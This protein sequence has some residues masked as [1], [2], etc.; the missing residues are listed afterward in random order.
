MRRAESP[1]RDVGQESKS[2]HK[3]SDQCHN[4]IVNFSLIHVGYK[5]LMTAMQNRSAWIVGHEMGWV[6]PSMESVCCRVKSTLLRDKWRAWKDLKRNRGQ[7]KSL[8]CFQHCDGT[9][10]QKPSIIFT[11]HSDRQ[12]ENSGILSSIFR[13][14]WCEQLRHSLFWNHFKQSLAIL[15]V[16][17]SVFESYRGL[18]CASVKK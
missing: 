18:V 16:S 14:A 1:A 6:S 11:S 7:L 5:T 15:R 2:L 13:N 8:C 4:R 12:P 3:N 10:I 17:K 9:G